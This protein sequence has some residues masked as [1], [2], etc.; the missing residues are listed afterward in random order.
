M[1]H[2]HNRYLGLPVLALLGSTK[3]PEG[4]GSALHRLLGLPSSEGDN[5]G[6]IFIPGGSFTMGSNRE[7]PEERFTHIVQVDGF[8]IDQHEVTNAE[9]D[10][11]VKAT[12]Y[13]TLAER[14][15]DP[16]THPGM[17]QDMLA[18][19]SVI[20]IPPRSSVAAATS[21]NGGNM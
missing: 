18:P 9:F 20:F 4:H 19:G 21:P 16:K 13:I 8:W 17:S 1:C 7:R 15:V 11:F 10:K 5:A 6:M 3:S 2:V 12:G 14:G